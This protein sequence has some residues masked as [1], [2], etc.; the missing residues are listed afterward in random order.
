MRFPKLPGRGADEAATNEAQPMPQQHT[1][2]ITTVPIPESV[3]PPL[4]SELT[5]SIRFSISEPQGYFFEQVETFVQQV[6]EV[7]AF[8]E[9]AEYKWQQFAYEMQLEVDEQ[10]HDAQ[11]LRSEIEL[12]KV[13]GSPM[14]NADGSYM[15]ESQ[16]S[17]LDKV[18]AD[19]NF[20]K[21]Q[22]SASEQARLVGQE[23]I[24]RLQ[25][26]A[27]MRDQEIASLRTW[28]EQVIVD[29]QALQ[30][31]AASLEAQLAAAQTAP[32]SA[33][34]LVAMSAAPAATPVE[35][36]EVVPVEVAPVESQSVAEGKYDDLGDFD[37]Q[38]PLVDVAALDDFEGDDFDESTVIADM[39]VDPTPATPSPTVA[40]AV[41]P[42]SVPVDLG[43]TPEQPVYEQV[44]PAH[45]EAHP[46]ATPAV[47]VQV[48][49]TYP[50]TEHTAHVA[51]AEHS[52]AQVAAG[53]PI[54]MQPSDALPSSVP[55]AVASAPSP[56][57][58]PV[59][60]APAESPTTAEAYYDPEPVQVSPAP[61]PV[62]VAVEGT[63]PS[64]MQPATEDASADE[65]G[66]SADDSAD[67]FADDFADDS[68]DDTE[69]VWNI[70]SELPEG[71]SL[72][73]TG[74][75]AYSY[76]AASPGAPLE[77]HGVPVGVWAPELDPRI[78][79]AL[80]QEANQQAG[81]PAQ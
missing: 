25:D 65:P 17:M 75:A 77:T 78:T 7:L 6:I 49:E 76:P 64:P 37:D 50:T 13:Q 29:M 43:Y 30:A 74:E 20:V 4:T 46:V 69:K 68:T 15:T 23:E 63:D 3:P 32:Q 24:N 58:V 62:P 34:G 28:G 31:H 53:Y 80:A 26:L 55:S 5:R 40:P 81:P 1:S 8:Y 18:S 54:P 47:D 70:D 61:V 48:A 11:R 35:V 59:E 38:V 44:A 60:P 19:L 52:V 42:A 2:V 14:V 72:P 21:D 67:D 22:L 9:Q 66:Y 57:A 16:T 41:P 79:Q 27:A 56:S 10:A 73:G 36:V 71:V 12:F 39:D 33:P 45:A 51:V